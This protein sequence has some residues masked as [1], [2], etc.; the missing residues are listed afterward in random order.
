VTARW[1]PTALRDLQSVHEYTSGDSP[2]AAD[3][4]IGT[5][6]DA[7]Q[8]LERSPGMGRRGRVPGTRELVVAPYVIAYRVEENVIA[9]LA[10][11]HGAQR[12]PDSF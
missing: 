10:I 1:P 9:L 2:D 5:L 8:A 7:I 6:L 3:R 11:I 4:V 12:W